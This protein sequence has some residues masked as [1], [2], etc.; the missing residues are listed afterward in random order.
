M[1]QAKEVSRIQ[2][3]TPHTLAE[4]LSVET[5]PEHVERVVDV[6]D[7]TA[8]SPGIILRRF[9]SW[10]SSNLMATGATDLK[11]ALTSGE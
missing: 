10:Y 3:T 4:P 7:S 9:G 5:D 1:E 11:K 2:Q 6:A 8:H